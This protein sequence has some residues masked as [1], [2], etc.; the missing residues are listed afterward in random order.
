MRKI[1]FISAFFLTMAVYAQKTDNNENLHDED[2]YFGT[3]EGITIYGQRPIDE[4]VLDQIN[5]SP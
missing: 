5:G 2:F 1:L 3:T 4:Y